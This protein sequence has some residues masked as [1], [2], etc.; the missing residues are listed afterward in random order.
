M[1]TSTKEKSKISRIY[2]VPDETTLFQKMLSLSL[3][4]TL[5]VSVVGC[6]NQPSLASTLSEFDSTSP[7][8]ILV[9]NQAPE[10]KISYVDLGDNEWELKRL[11][12][13]RESFEVLDERGIISKKNSDGFTI[14]NTF[15]S[16]RYSDLETSNEYLEKTL[17]LGIE[18]IVNAEN[19]KSILGFLEYYGSYYIVLNEDAAIVLYSLGET[20]TFEG[21]IDLRE[22]S[23]RAWNFFCSKENA[24]ETI[25]G[26]TGLIP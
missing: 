15:D 6:S 2:F 25:Y 8:S 4:I 19:N 5:I 20:P 17:W 24:P 11:R 1:Y 18:S 10:L 21:S 16:F 26:G 3:L 13:S 22:F 12:L 7:L 9:K 14:R 23:E